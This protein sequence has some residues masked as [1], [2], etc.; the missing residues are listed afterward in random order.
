[1]LPFPSRGR[2]AKHVALHAHTQRVDLGIAKSYLVQITPDPSLHVGGMF[3]IEER[4]EQIAPDIISLGKRDRMCGAER[5]K[6]ISVLSRDKQKL[7]IRGQDRER[8]PV[9]DL[10]NVRA[11]DYTGFRGRERIARQGDPAARG[12][13][14]CRQVP[15]NQAFAL[16]GR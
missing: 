14:V 16:R 3:G 15:G 2:Q 13:D 12:I 1:M 5:L 4:I 11:L 6:V 8:E 10:N 9:D 7:T